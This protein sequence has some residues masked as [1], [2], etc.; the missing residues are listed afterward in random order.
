MPSA[1]RRFHMHATSEKNPAEL[2]LAAPGIAAQPRHVK[3]KSRSKAGGSD[4]A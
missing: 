1:Q 2:G 3:V 4:V